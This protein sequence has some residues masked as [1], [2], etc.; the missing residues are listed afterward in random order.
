MARLCPRIRSE[1]DVNPAEEFQQLLQRSG[2]GT[3]TARVYLTCLINNPLTAE[4]I[5][6]KSLTSIPH[7]TKGLDKLYKLHLVAFDRH[8][9][10][11]LWFAMDPIIAWRHL[12]D[13]ITW[14]NVNVLGAVL[15][16]KLEEKTYGDVLYWR[17]FCAE[18]E[19]LSVDLYRPYRPDFWQRARHAR[20]PEEMAMLECLAVQTAKHE[21]ISV[22]PS[23]RLPHVALI[24]NA[25]LVARARDAQ[26]WRIADLIEVIDHGLEIVERD[27]HEVGVRFMILEQDKLHHRFYVMDE[28][29]AIIYHR[30]PDD[31][32][33]HLLIGKLTGQRHEVQRYRSRFASYRQHAIPGNFVVGHLRAVS[34]HIL[35]RCARQYGSVGREWLGR[36]VDRGIFARFSDLPALTEKKAQALETW[37]F[38][39]GIVARGSRNRPVPVYP[40][41]EAEIRTAWEQLTEDERRSTWD[42]LVSQ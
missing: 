35:D 13:E 15:E 38:R 22:S 10:T 12:R 23:P 33:R 37:A 3:Q 36:L 9:D 1:T 16:P 6:S 39:E 18:A 8:Y 7:V 19:R 30:T 34:R 40:L 11:Q 20:D 14:K 32:N 29:L 25:L 24:W 41:T 5:A 4:Q 27:M 2:V 28:N 42:R 31:R 21:I 26:Y 17:T